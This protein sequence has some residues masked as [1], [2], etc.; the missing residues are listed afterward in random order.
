MLDIMLD[1]DGDIAVT[2]LGDIRT[3]ESVRQAVKIRLKWIFSE[4]RLGPD[5]GFPWFEEVFVRNPNIP[6]IKQ[7]VKD[8]IM[9][10]DEVEDAEV[11]KAAYDPRTRTAAFTYTVT[12]DEFT[13]REE[14]TLYG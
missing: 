3:T 13:Y 1:K 10:V 7:L 6:K 14:V 11:I 5:Y 2:A 4:W 9:K 12:I 8:E